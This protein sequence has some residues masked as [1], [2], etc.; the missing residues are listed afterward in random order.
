[1]IVRLVDS[2]AKAFHSFDELREFLRR[3]TCFGYIVQHP[4]LSFM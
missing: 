3:D 1:L 2:L 4:P